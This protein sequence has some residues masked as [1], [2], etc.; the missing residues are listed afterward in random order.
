MPRKV[1]VAKLPIKSLDTEDYPDVTR[2]YRQGMDTGMATFE[3][4]VPNWCS[5]SAKFLPQCQFVI[6]NQTDLLGWCAL[7]RGST[8]EVYKGVAETTIGMPSQA[9]GMGLGKALLDY[10]AKASEEKGFWTL[11]A[12]IYPPKKTSV[13]LHQQCGFRT[14]AY[15]EQIAQRQGVWYDHLSMETRSKLN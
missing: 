7:S 12:A 13:K 15:R 3:T 8:R 2:I 6:A 14:I 1:D 9:R 11:Q 4:T 5:W 10:L